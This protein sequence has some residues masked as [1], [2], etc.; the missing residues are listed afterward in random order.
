MFFLRHQM[1]CA[2]V[3]REQSRFNYIMIIATEVAH[4]G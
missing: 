2:L 4:G 3:F 1:M